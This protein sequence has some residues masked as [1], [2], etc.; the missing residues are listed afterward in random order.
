MNCH[1]KGTPDDWNGL[2]NG[3]SL[4]TAAPGCGLPI[5]NLTSQLFSNIY[6]NELDQFM[7][8]EL[9]CR[10]YGRYVDDFYVVGADRIWL[11]SLIP[12]VREFL[13]EVLGLELHGGKL[14]IDGVL[15]GIEFIGADLKPYRKYISNDSLKRMIPK[16]RTMLEMFISG[17]LS[18]NRVLSSL[19]SFKGVLSHWHNT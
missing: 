2:D 5:G 15:Q 18:P 19:S 13:S 9:H 7:K 8:R 17:K 10:H 4:F 11:R 1:I 14:R 12:K 3:K 16:T 6:L